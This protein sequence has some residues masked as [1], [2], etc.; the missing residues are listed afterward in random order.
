MVIG[1]MMMYNICVI[2]P[3]LQT[4]IIGSQRIN[5]AIGHCPR[6]K[7]MAVAYLVDNDRTDR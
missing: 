7:I 3:M 1:K 4:I 2:L 6:D 5:T